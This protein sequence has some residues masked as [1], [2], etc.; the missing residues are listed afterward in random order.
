MK[1][2]AYSSDVSFLENLTLVISNLKK[3]QNMSKQEEYALERLINLRQIANGEKKLVSEKRKYSDVIRTLD[4]IGLTQTQLG[5]DFIDLHD[6][7]ADH[8][9]IPSKK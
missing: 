1:F 6:Y 3:K 2:K 7:F 5:R 4:E 8:Y 9:T